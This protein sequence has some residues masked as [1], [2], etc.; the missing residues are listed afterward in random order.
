[1]RVVNNPTIRR[2]AVLLIRD[3]RSR[4]VCSVL[5]RHEGL[6]VLEASTVDDLIALAREQS[7]DLV[8]ADVDVADRAAFH[9][10]LV[11]HLPGIP[12]L[13]IHERMLPDVVAKQVRVQIHPERRGGGAN[14]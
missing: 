14:N 7:I 5:L 2:T 10:E 4:T 6:R 13:F 12:C 11:T 1:M 3:A 9:L 8:L